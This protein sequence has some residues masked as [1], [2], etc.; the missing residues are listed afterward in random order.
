MPYSL[1]SGIQVSI[2]GTTW[3]RLTDHNRGEIDITPLLIE[4]EARMANGTLR[5]FVVAKKDVISVSWDF[6]PTL[7]VDNTSNIQSA[8]VV[9]NTIVFVTSSAHNFTTSS[10]ITVRG[11]S[12][13]G[14]NVTGVQPTS[15]SGTT[16]VVPNSLGA[17]GIGT[18]P[19]VARDENRPS[20]TTVDGNY[21]AG[22]ISAFYNANCGIPIYVKIVSS[23]YSTPSTGQVP[24]DNTYVTAANGETVYQAFMTGFSNTIR[25]RTRTTDYADITL[26]FTEI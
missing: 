16:F 6:L 24:A 14:F 23:K 25:K 12:P 10:S 13:S 5:K 17:A 18:G 8:T 22:W 19:G 20:L 15:A 21:G 7:H 26:E 11:L 3:Y 2:N 1:Q 9:G 4:K